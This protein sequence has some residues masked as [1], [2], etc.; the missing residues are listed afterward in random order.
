MSKS[1]SYLFFKKVKLPLLVYD[2]L[3][4]FIFTCGLIL[5]GTCFIRIFFY[6][7]NDEEVTVWENRND[8]SPQQITENDEPSERTPLI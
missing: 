8:E 7:K 1:V 3:K 4:Y 6:C 5:F 2:C